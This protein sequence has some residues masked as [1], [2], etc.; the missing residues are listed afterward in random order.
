[1][2]LILSIIIVFKDC[3]K[4]L[5]KTLKSLTKVFDNLPNSRIE[6]IFVD[7]FS[8]DGSREEAERFIDANPTSSRIFLQYPRGIYPAMNLGAA[9]AQ[10]E[11]ILYL[12]AGDTLYD[13][14]QIQATLT[15]AKLLK[16]QAIQFNSGIRSPNSNTATWVKKNW[17]RCHQAYIYKKDLHNSLGP[18]DES[19]RVCSDIEFLCKIPEKL[20]LKE[21]SVLSITQVSPKNASRNPSLIE[22]DM[23]SLQRKGYLSKIFPRP[24]LTLFILRVEKKLGISLSVWIKSG[25]HIMRRKSCLIYLDD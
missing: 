22:E 10:G 6:I 7:G 4:D 16:K 8:I 15:E 2:R 13:T 11:W 21:S 14:A 9:M 17:P 3:K 1:M 25:Y 20:T 24:R 18:Y 23:K 5:H 19:L 12:N